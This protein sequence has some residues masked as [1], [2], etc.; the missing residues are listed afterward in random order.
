MVFQVLPFGEITIVYQALTAYNKTLIAKEYNLRHH[1]VESR[2]NCLAY[3]RNLCAHSDRVWNRTMTKKLKIK[4]YE[5][6]FNNN[7]DSLFSY[8]LVIIYFL[9]IISPSSL[10]LSKLKKLIKTHKSINFTSM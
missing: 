5:E 8:L 9:K 1:Y 10:W 6:H 2:I 3:L 7:I 4:G